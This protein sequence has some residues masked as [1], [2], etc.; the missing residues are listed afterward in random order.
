MSED[1]YIFMNGRNNGQGARDRKRDQSCLKDNNPEVPM[2]DIP[3]SVNSVY[4][5][6]TPMAT[7]LRETVYFEE[8]GRQYGVR[9]KCS[10]T[11]N[12]NHKS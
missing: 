1:P 6:A 5:T 4:S 9:E 10:G 11:K 12:R 8:L 7:D 3:N 2:P